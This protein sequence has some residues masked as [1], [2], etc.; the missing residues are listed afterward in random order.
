LFKSDDFKLLEKPALLEILK[1]DDFFA[2]EIIIWENILKWG[3]ARHPEISDINVKEWTLQNF[4]DLGNTMKE[5]LYLIRYQ[6]ISN[7]DFFDKIVPYQTLFPKTLWDNFLQYYIVPDRRS[8]LNL[9]PSRKPNN[10]S[11]SH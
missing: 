7:E 8:T 1:K 6:D 2:D 10:Q 9:L 4:I 5:F 11:K 3:L